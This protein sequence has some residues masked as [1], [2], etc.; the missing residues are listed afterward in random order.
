MTRDSIRRGG[1]AALMAA[2]L[3]IGSGTLLQ[4][5]DVPATPKP[6]EPYG[7]NARS[8]KPVTDGL[9]S[10]LHGG[11]RLYVAKCAA[12]HSLTRSLQKADLSAE[13][14]GDIVDRMRNRPASHLNDTQAR[15]IV[16]YL[17]WNDQQRQKK[18]EG[19]K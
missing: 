12:C 3:W 11:H 15:A 19:S 1:F 16:A 6:P 2:A 13:E 18:A 10:E 5:Q 7:Q 17:V 14:W 4:A 9:P 8:L